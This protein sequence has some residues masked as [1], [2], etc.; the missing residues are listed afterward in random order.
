M[1]REIR[2]TALNFRGAGETVDIGAESFG[3]TP[4]KVRRNVVVSPL[5]KTDGVAGAVCAFGKFLLG[6]A[7]V[8]TPTAHFTGN[9]HEELFIWNLLHKS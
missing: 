4:K 8:M 3:K 2:K 7:L 6:P 9:L 1:K 5:D